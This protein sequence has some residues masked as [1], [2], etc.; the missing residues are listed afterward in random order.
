[1]TRKEKT[2]ELFKKHTPTFRIKKVDDPFF[3]LKSAYFISGKKGKFIQLFESELGR[4]K[5]IYMEFVKKDLSPDLADRPLFKLVYNP[6]YKEE[7]EMENKI[8]DEGKEYSV[9]IISVAEL[10][11]VLTN[12]KEVSYTDYENGVTTDRNQTLFPDFEEEYSSKAE[13]ELSN[14]EIAD[15]PLSEIT[16]RDLAAIMLM[17][18][19]SARPWLNELV[20]QAKSEI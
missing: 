8:T 4:D 11:V 16:I 15:T 17:K 2:E 13:V 12:G 3:T 6:F 18:P 1:M 10:K 5:D 9:Y 20:K 7:Y 19:V 14:E